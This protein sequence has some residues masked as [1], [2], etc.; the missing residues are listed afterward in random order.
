MNLPAT[1]YSLEKSVTNF[2]E[3]T[4]VLTKARRKM[5]KWRYRSTHQLAMSRQ[6]QTLANLRAGKARPLPLGSHK[7]YGR[8]G[9]EISCHCQESNTKP[10]TSGLQYKSTT[11]TISFTNTDMQAISQLI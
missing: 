2:R 9:E 11:R 4:A 8:F 3:I 7:R 1:G 10:R 5:G 6:L